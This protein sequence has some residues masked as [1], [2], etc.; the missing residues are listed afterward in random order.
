VT[1]PSYVDTSD[2]P[3]DQVADHARRVKLFA[4]SLRDDLATSG[5]FRIIPLDC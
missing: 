5:K 4:D 3:H 1:T 2:E